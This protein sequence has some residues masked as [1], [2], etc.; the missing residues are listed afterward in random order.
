MNVRRALAF[1]VFVA[2]LIACGSRRAVFDD[3]LPANSLGPSGQLDPDAS[4]LLGGRDP[5]TCE[6]AARTRSYV[7][8][9]YWPTVT[10][11]MVQ[12]VFD[13]AVA[14]ANVGTEDAEVTITGPEAVNQKI[15]VGA[16]RLEKVFLPWVPRLKSSDT[17]VLASLLLK[18]GAYHLVSSR[19]VVVYQ[20]NPLEFAGT[21]GPPEKDWTA[22]EAQG[23]TGDCY[24]YSNDASLLLPSTAM[25]GT[26]RIMGPSGQSRYPINFV[27][28][29]Y[30]TDEPLEN[31]TSG[32]VVVTATER[33]TTVNLKL[34]SKAT[35][36]GG[37][38]VSAGSP[39]DSISFVLDAG[40]VGLIAT[41]PNMAYDISGSLL[42]A[43]KPVQ[44]ITGVPCAI[45]PHEFP[46]CDHL[47]ETVFPAETLGKHYVVPRPTGPRENIVRH[48]V[49]FYGNVDGTTL[50]YKPSMPTGCPA[51]LSAGEV[52]ECSGLVES[53]FEVSSDR[54]F[55]VSMFLLGGAIT[56][57][58]DAGVLGP[59][60]GDPS[61]SFAVSVE[62]YRQRYVF[63]A[64]ADYKSNYVDV[65]GSADVKLTVDGEDVSAELKLIDGTSWSIARVRLSVGDH[66][67]AHVLDA[68]APVGIQVIGYGDYTSYQYPGGLN[69]GQI[70]P[71][72]IH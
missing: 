13:F 52:A 1:V 17:Y 44:V 42:T 33:G 70:A 55:G 69:L 53:D 65:I 48:V 35:I 63:L 30:E 15:T 26:Y 67:G 23:S 24:S 31:F 5:S 57:P 28:G 22:C 12:D 71:P 27:T 56:D 60:Q 68:S 29:A 14:V 58:N 51:T 64:P 50:A 49:R 34:G 36:V 3:A 21:G 20:F 72:P 16:G 9:D 4:T 2:L 47:E 8:C 25:T 32:Y 41:P 59:L 38:S 18:G 39:G 7:G 6:E 11:N 37:G 19:P 10:P 62:Q 54:E 45:I 43:D 61:L 66:D 46:A 40:D